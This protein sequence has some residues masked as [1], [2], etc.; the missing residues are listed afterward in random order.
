MALTTPTTRPPCGLRGPALRAAL[1][2]LRRE[3]GAVPPSVPESPRPAEVWRFEEVHEVWDHGP[4]AMAPRDLAVWLE[5]RSLEP[6]S[7]IRR[8]EPGS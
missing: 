2:E 5:G 4:R 7:G 6:E 3:E 8:R 1:N